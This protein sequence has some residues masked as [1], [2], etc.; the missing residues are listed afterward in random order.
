MPSDGQNVSTKAGKK[1]TQPKKAP[2]S[3]EFIESEAE[4]ER[5]PKDDKGEK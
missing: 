4:E 1:T 2:K 3:P 5:S